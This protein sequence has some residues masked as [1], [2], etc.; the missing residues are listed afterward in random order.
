MDWLDGFSEEEMELHSQARLGSEEECAASDFHDRCAHIYRTGISLPASGELQLIS[1]GDVPSETD[2][3][4]GS[5]VTQLE[6]LYGDSH[7]RSTISY[8]C[9]HDGFL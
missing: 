4:F 5:L 8:E 7:G 2:G 9:N 1:D 6:N 3:A